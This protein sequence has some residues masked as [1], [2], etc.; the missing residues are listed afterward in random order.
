MERKKYAIL[1]LLVGA[2]IIL[3]VMCM[4]DN[5][6]WTLPV[7]I[8]AQEIENL[9][10]DI[11]S[12]SISELTI[13]ITGQDVPVTIEPAA[14]VTFNIQGDVNIT[15]TELDVNVTNSTLNVTGDVNATVQG[16]ADINIKNAEITVDVATVR[17]KAS[18]ENKLGYGDDFAS[19]DPGTSETITLFNNTLGETVYVELLT[20]IVYAPLTGGTTPNL[21]DFYG[22]F[23]FYD[24]GGVRFARIYV[25]AQTDVKNL[26]PAIPLPPGGYVRLTVG[27]S[28]SSAAYFAGSVV[29]RKS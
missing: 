20:L 4:G 19:V 26:D 7:S 24:S 27:N 29:Y 1:A 18:E 2:I 28:G 10:V 25:N 14:G 3:G 23:D 9:S 12:Q 17:E 13:R 16:T 21:A 22:T 5:P 6:D 15:N 8:R 11:A